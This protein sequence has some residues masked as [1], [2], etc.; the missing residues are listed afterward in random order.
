MSSE[1]SA[2]GANFTDFNSTGSQFNSTGGQF[3]NTAFNATSQAT[4]VRISVY[5]PV[6]YMS[7]LLLLLVIFSIVY[8]RRKLNELRS[9]PSLF[10]ENRAKEMYLQLKNQKDP[11]VNEKLLKTALI[12]RGAEAIKRMLKLK[13]CEVYIN[14]LY[15]KGLVGDEDHERLKIEKKVEE[16]ELREL[17]MEA[18][19]YKKGWSQ[20]FFAVC[21]EAALNEA[22]RR[23]LNSEDD[24]IDELKN[25]WSVTEM[26]IGDN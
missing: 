12:R 21:Q 20:S 17:A 3:N 26:K 8:R 23:R 16:V 7:V 15:L 13:E 10:R 25:E 24:R 1:S 6:I 18:E 19:T 14:L 2:F 22:L 9:M 4:K 11:K 5:T